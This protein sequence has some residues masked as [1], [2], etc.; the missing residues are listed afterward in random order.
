MNIQ[1]TAAPPSVSTRAQTHDSCAGFDISAMHTWRA[2]Y[3]VFNWLCNYPQREIW[4]GFFRRFCPILRV[5]FRGVVVFRD[6]D[7]REVLAHDHEFPV[8]WGGRMVEVT[9]DQ[10]FVLGMK[11]GPQYRRNYEQLAKAFKREDVAK[12]VVPKAAERSSEYLNGKPSIDGKTSIDAVRDL[13]WR[14]PAKLCDDYYGI[15]IP[16]NEELRLAEWTVAMSSYLFGTPTGNISTSGWDLALSAADCFRTLI[17]SA[18]QKTKDGVRRGIV[19]PRLIEMQQSDPHL[20]DE[21]LEAHLFGMVTG[22]IP[23]DLLAGGN[24]LNTLLTR[25]DFMAKARAAA[26]DDDDELLWRCLQEAL[27]FRHFNLGPYRICGPDG[28]T[29]AA[30]TGRAKYLP[31]GSPVLASTQSAM[32]DPRQVERPRWF[33]PDRAPEDY[34]VFGYG[35]HWC[36]G[37]YIAIAQITQTFKALLRKPGLRRAHGKLGK[38]ETITVYPAHLWVEFDE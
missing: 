37:E 15:E 2:F 10:N 5:P 1:E 26:L 19:L 21:V 36:L 29:L 23:T 28:Y 24:I 16:K 32:F 4:M 8:P 27:R 7:V 35:Q 20:T 33:D 17:R 18:I 30:G 9:G 14:V 38:L 22:F 3:C 25:K 6:E 12:Y 11:D 13:I 34:M 31:P